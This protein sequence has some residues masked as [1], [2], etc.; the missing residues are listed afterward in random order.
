[1]PQL[2]VVQLCVQHVGPIDL[3]VMPA[4]IIC[5]SGASGSGKSLLLRALADLIPHAG[6][7]FLDA[8]D[9]QHLS[10]VQWRRQVGY[11]PA[12][13]Q[14][15]LETVAE[16]FSQPNAELLRELGF[17]TP[18]WQWPIARLSSG[19]KQRLGLLRLLQ[20]TPACLL[21][22]EPTA[23]LDQENTLRVEA[24]VKQ[25]ATRHQAAVIWVSHNPAQIQR[26]AAQHWRLQQ[27]TIVNHD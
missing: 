21:L 9:A 25:Y 2:R 19:E 5:L 4:E 11:L 18:A 27:G 22:D 14:W 16:H 24:V 6:H 15:W 10:P 12:E 26:I 17:D 3:T 8:I 23:S 13:S 20:H 7:V 1:M